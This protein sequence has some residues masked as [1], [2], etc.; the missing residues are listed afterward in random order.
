MLLESRRGE[1]RKTDWHKALGAQMRP[2][3]K[4]AVIAVGMK[5]ETGWKGEGS[6]DPNTSRTFRA[7]S[8]GEKGFSMNASRIPL[9]EIASSV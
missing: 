4:D 9:S 7:R 3:K 1:R 5:R 6:Y 2:F 8:V